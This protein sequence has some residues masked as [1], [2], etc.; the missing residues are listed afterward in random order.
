VLGQA[1]A[2][3]VEY[4][5]ARIR[6]ALRQVEFKPGKPRDLDSAPRPYQPDED[7][8]RVEEEIPFIEVG[9]RQTPMEASPSVLASIPKTVGKS[10]RG[11]LQKRPMG[12]SRSAVSSANLRLSRVS[13][14][15]F[16]PESSPLRPIA[17]RFD[18]D[19]VAL[20]Q[21]DHP[22]SA[23][24][25]VLVQNI[26]EQLP[27][28][29]PRVLLFTSATSQS[30]TVTV[31]LNLAITRAKQN[32]PRDIVVDANF[33][34][35]V[36]AERLGLPLVPGLGDVLAGT[37]SLSRALQETGQPNLSALTAG[38]GGSISFEAVRTVMRQL[39]G[40]F[41][42]IF[43]NGPCWGGLPDLITLGSACDAVY[44]VL[45]ES[46]EGTTKMEDV[47][48]TILQQG[49]CLQGCFVVG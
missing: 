8:P 15:P 3:H 26:E 9:D 13:F 49:G 28:G 2:N 34:R 11:E 32:R 19:L 31:L 14:R 23:E 1:H 21:P 27:C 38:K 45:S 10:E 35:P 6:E 5:M 24:Y 20:H 43:V 48:E 42:W 18:T 41:D 22:I 29:Q 36:L 47:S 44:L 16:P 33:R 30:D 12:A 37:V 39:R 7:G 17:Q 25:R 46:D 4:I 40:R